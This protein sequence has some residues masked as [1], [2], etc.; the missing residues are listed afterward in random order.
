MPGD[1][2]AW[3]A[4]GVFWL[5]E[6]ADEAPTAALPAAAEGGAETAMSGVTVDAMSV[7]TMCVINASLS[8]FLVAQHA[9]RRTALLRSLIAHARASCA[10][11]GVF[12]AFGELLKFWAS[13]Y[14]SH[15]C[16]REF[17][18]FSSGVPFA[19]WRQVVKDLRRDLAEL[20]PS[21]VSTHQQY[22]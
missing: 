4:G 2:G 17:L 16:E 12:A 5:L 1:W 8:F 3:T 10:D 19:T 15:S 14:D 11:L 9:G 6:C 7:E 21:D 22:Q 18:T 20:A 13:V